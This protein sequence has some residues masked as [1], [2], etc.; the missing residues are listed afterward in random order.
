[1]KKKTVVLF[2][3]IYLLFMGV[4]DYPFIA[5]I[6]N[7]QDQSRAI[8]NYDKDIKDLTQDEIE[9]SLSE[10]I[11][12]NESLNSGLHK[13]KLPDSFEEQSNGDSYYNSLLNTNKDKVMAVIE[14]PKIKIELPIYHGTNDFSLENG[15]GHVE[16]S[17]LPI[18]G[19]STHACIAAHRGLP[20]K[21]MF[22]DLDQI[23][24]GDIFFIKVYDKKL[25]YR[26]YDTEVV[27]PDKVDSLQ[28]KQEHDEISL[29]TCT[30]YGVNSHR[31]YIHAERIPYEDELEEE[32]LEDFNFFRTYWW[33][34]L[35]IALFIWMLFLIFIIHR[36]NKSG[37]ERKGN[38]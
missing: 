20:N 34:F 7:E 26:V 24:R 5:R 9:Y 4:M 19:D 21:K 29:I 38:L 33:V 12:Y 37:K 1:M 3:L 8:S 28:I 10:A 25:A 36:K 15:A 22:T 17:S 31:I 18:G 27:T 35:N 11:S 16:G 32:A 23:K 6:I 30:P 13:Q 14:I 2:V